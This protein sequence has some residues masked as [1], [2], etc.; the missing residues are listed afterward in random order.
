M[1]TGYA[2]R[3]IGLVFVPRLLGYRI[4]NAALGSKGAG[5]RV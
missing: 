2:I 4:D 5:I 3:Q 1:V